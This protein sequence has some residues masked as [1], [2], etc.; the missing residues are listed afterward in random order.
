MIRRFVSITGVALALAATALAAP[1]ATAP[2]A[3]PTAPPDSQPA[4]ATLTVLAAMSS[5]WV[6]NFNP[7]NETSRL[8][9][10]REFIYEPLVVF[11]SMYGGRPEYRLATDYAFSPDLLKL[12]FKLRDGVQ[13]SDGQPF[14][15]ADVAY[16]FDLLRRFRALDTLDMGNRV[17]AVEAVD[18][19]T[20][21]FTLKKVNTS[22]VF[23]IVRV[24]V[25][26]RHIWSKVADPVTFT[27][28]APV[29]TGPMTEV[30][31]F[32]PQVY[33]QCRNPNYWDG[34]DLKVDCMSFPQV[35]NNEQL[36]TAAA[37]GRLDWF[38]AFLP[39]IERT[40]VAADPKHHRYWFPPGGTV[41]IDINLNS[42]SRGNRAAF[43]NVNFRRAVSMAVDRR[44]IVDIAGYGYPE[45]NEYASGIGRT[46]Q[47]WV[48]PEAER[49]YGRYAHFD[50]NGAQALLA[51]SGFRDVNGDGYIDNA[52]GSPIAFDILVPTGWTDWVNS[53]QLV[54]ESLN[55][56][57]L[58]VRV[59]TVE[60]ASWAQ[61]L[62]SGD[63]DMAING[64][65]P[66]E[67]PYRS[68][69]TGFHSRYSGKTRFAPTRFTDP[70][71]D[72]ALDAFVATI[73]PTEQ[74]RAMDKVQMIVAA[75]SPYVPL[76]SNP[77]WY[78]YNTRRFKGWFN[79]DN[80]VAR[81][82]VFD[83]TP[84]RLLHLLA[85]EPV[86]GQAAAAAPPIPSAGGG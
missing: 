28:D 69:D 24:P 54:A 42:P 78:E 36:L 64:L 8:P 84:E 29:G 65:F 53:T 51:E 23:E 4:P 43:R 10:V 12:T 82:D 32:T 49:Q 15:A 59:S 66:G 60:P 57:G 3:A 26:P 11:N 76:F 55:A 47:D 35:R 72:S 45:V 21:V 18:A 56:L 63:Y 2:I 80:P 13:W 25:V 83:G 40:Y 48:N 50:K 33:V 44:A 75:N 14:T 20:V 30:K 41:A 22:I 34:A 38:G 9:S 7:F 79:A 61:K 52:D 46:Y 71:L 62:I 37:E 74:R 58:N 1:T 86:K 68:F 19:H 6:R 70:D 67:T 81:P 73:D 39:D 77:T 17:A 16:T 31:R 27:N 5:G 85:L